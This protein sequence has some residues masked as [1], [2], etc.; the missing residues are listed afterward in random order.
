MLLQGCTDTDWN[1]PPRE[2]RQHV[3][4]RYLNFRCLMLGE[5]NPTLRNVG[6]MFLSYFTFGKYK[7]A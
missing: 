3:E 5:M 4:T 1:M 7:G 2:P 6:E